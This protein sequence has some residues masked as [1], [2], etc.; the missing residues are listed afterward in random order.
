[1]HLAE[2][3]K[4]PLA[5]PFWIV[6]FF[7]FVREGRVIQG[8]FATA[9]SEQ[10][11]GT[12][13]ALV[14]GSPLALVAAIAASFLPWLT[15]GWP[16]VA[17]VLGMALLI[18]GAVLR[19]V[20][21]NALGKSFTGTVIV[22]KDQTIV[23]NGPYRFVRHPSYTAAFLM[24]IGIGLALCSWISLAILFFAHCYLYG[25]RVAVE[26]RALLDTLGTPYREY[27]SRTR[28]FIPFVI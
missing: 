23:Q 9:P 25:R 26:E 5:I 13:R 6:F 21:F 18:A 28:R 3:F 12:F 2:I 27:M 7:A 24:F 4:L 10:D 14:I 16:E 11:A 20:C 8:S 17:V 15:I 22:A 19:R 1:M